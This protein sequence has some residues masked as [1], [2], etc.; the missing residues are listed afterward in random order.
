MDYNRYMAQA[1]RFREMAKNL[2]GYQQRAVLSAACECE[3]KAWA[4]KRQGEQP[5]PKPE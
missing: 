3:S 1:A 4:L 5:D 2:D